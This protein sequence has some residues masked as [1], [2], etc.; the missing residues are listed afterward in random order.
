MKALDQESLY[1]PL[2]PKVS[3]YKLT[4]I[5]AR[6]YRKRYDKVPVESE[7]DRVRKEHD[8]LEHGYGIMDLE[9]VLSECGRYREVHIFNRSRAITV[10]G[11]RKYVP[12]VVALP[13]QG[14]FTEYI[15][16]ERGFHTQ[17]DFNAKC[18]KCV[19]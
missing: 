6:L 4:D 10:S 16:Y 2:T 13:V 17:P 9:R 14:N 11:N 12:D 19:R 5:G 18:N 1:L 8:N 7:I 15:E 3:V